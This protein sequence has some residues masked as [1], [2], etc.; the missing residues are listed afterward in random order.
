M[1]PLLPVVGD[2]AAFDDDA[3]AGDNSHMSAVH[4]DCTFFFLSLFF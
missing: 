1:S 3:V 4:F 2:A